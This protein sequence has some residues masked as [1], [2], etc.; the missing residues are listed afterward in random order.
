KRQ[1]AKELLIRLEEAVPAFQNRLTVLDVWTPVT[2][3]RFCNAYH[4]SYMSF[5]TTKK[6]KSR[7]IPGVLKKLPNV[8][9]ASQWLMGS[10]GLPSAAATGRFAAYRICKQEHLPV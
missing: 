10:G 5:I 9:L 6:A 8:M 4:N 1:L 7:Q 3:Q 2:Y